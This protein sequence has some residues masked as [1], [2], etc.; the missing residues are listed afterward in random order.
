MADLR[1][2]QTTVCYCKLCPTTMADNDHLVDDLQKEMDEAL[3]RLTDPSDPASERDAAVFRSLYGQFLTEPPTVDWSKIEPLPEG[4][5]RD[6]AQLPQPN[7]AQ[8]K[9]LLQQIAVIKLNG[10]LGTS[11]GCSGPK[12]LIQVRKGKTFLDMAIDQIKHMNEM[13]E[14]AVPLI[15]MNS[16]NTDKDTAR[17]LKR[18]DRSGN[19]RTFT[20]SRCPRIFKD[21]LMPVPQDSHDRPDDGWY[22]PGHGNIFQSMHNSGLLD[23]L[24][25]EGREYCFVSNIDN[26]GATV[27]LRIAH[28]L[29]AEQPDYVME[30]TEK[31]QAD[32]KGGTLIK[33]ND[34]IMHLELPQVPKDHEEDFKSINVFS[35]FNT[36]NIWVNLKAIKRLI[37]TDDMKME[38]IVNPKTT[39]K[40]EDVL[41]LETSIGGAIRNFTN[42]F[43]LKVARNRFLPVK[44]TQDMLLIMS[45][46]FR[47]E[48]G[49]LI[50]NTKRSIPQMPLIK[51]SSHFDHVK[52]F[53][54]R[55]KDTPDMLQLLHLTVVGDV[56]FGR[57]ITLTG[58]VIIV[59]DHGSTIEIPDGS[60]IGNKI[61]TGSLRFLEH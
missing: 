36:N 12:S 19:I 50:A 5:S 35:I 6:Y 17:A 58:T 13:Y 28:F 16:F 15:L 2:T 1:R 18:L 45:N 41:Q 21:S 46:L 3:T 47:L 61:A 59:A 10:G 9:N 8:A 14:V 23:E 55:F 26:T 7:A 34:K 20:Q 31:T 57:N 30:V 54:K 40:G 24:I 43:C 32:V 42:V 11:M 27:D 4:I 29:I 53:L 44:K 39:S 25:S 60:V 38:I 22:P 49:Q 48:N 37:E 51:L 56:H 52:N 33:I